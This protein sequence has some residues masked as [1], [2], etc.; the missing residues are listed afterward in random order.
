MAEV[1]LTT[2]QAAEILKLYERTVRWHIL[3]GRYTVRE[4]NT[5]C[6]G[7]CAKRYLIALSSLSRE[8]QERYA[9]LYGQ[10]EE[11]E[12]TGAGEPPAEGASEQCGAEIDDAGTLAEVESRLSDEEYRAI[13]DEAWR[14][15]AIC[16]EALA[17]KDDPERGEKL[18]RLRAEHN[19]SERTLR[20]WVYEYLR[21]GLEGLIDQRYRQAV[22]ARRVAPELIEFIRRTYLQPHKPTAQY[23]YEQTVI[24]ARE[25]GLPAPSRA[26]VYRIITED[27]L[28]GEQVMGREGRKAFR[29][30]VEPK[31]RRDYSDLAK[32]EIWTGDGHVLPVFVNINGRAV[33]P[34]LSAWMDLRTRVIT[35]WCLAAQGNSVTIGLALRHGILPKPDSPIQGLPGTVYTDN[36]KDYRSK[37]SAAVCTRLRIDER[38][39]EAYSPWAK[40]IERFFETMHNR[41]TRHLPGYCAND[42]NQRP[43]GFDEKRLLAEGRL[44]TLEELAARF[45]AWLDKDYHQRKHSELGATPLKVY[46]SLP[47]FREEMPGPRELDILLMKEDEV[48]IYPD[49]IRRFGHRYWADELIPYVL[50]TV[51]IRYDPNRAGEVV[52]FRRGRVLCVAK[53]AELLSMKATEEQVKEHQRRKRRARKFFAE[54]LRELE[55]PAAA[56]GNPKVAGAN[57]EAARAPVRMVTGFEKAAKLRAEEDAEAAEAQPKRD[58]VKEF[59]LAV[60]DRVAARITNK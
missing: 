5:G 10:A 22:R 58:R 15:A 14:K 39:C 35:G 27:I 30:K 36:G 11:V 53:C 19:V 8:A 32:N 40:P 6:S 33:K 26:T 55:E 3:R 28:P 45:A 2:G 16:E 59:L 13:M 50:E 43:E 1:W 34:T 44:L 52:V 42:K 46:N 56:R 21:E 12:D 4:E 57:D 24:K 31:C 48:K 47:P 7:A 18:R 20:R 60:G 41:F 17:L 29:Q 54:R 23:V 49:G 9:E 38:T 25:L 37:H 51:V